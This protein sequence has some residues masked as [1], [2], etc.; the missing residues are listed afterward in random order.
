MK[1]IITNPGKSRE[2]H[3]LNY[4]AAGKYAGPAIV[5]QEKTDQKMLGFGAALTDSACILLGRMD[6]E[7]REA[8]L[9]E[10][11]SPQEGN[12]SVGRVCVGASDYADTPYSFAP[13]PDDMEMKHFD[14]SHDD[15]A[16]L[17][18]LRTC[19]KYNPDLYLFASPWS[20]PGWMKTSGRLQSGW[21]R[22]KYIDAFALYYLK[23]LRYY[24]KAGVKLNGLT[25]Q[26]ETETDQLGKMPACLWHPE[27]ET[28]FAMKM[29]R[30]L[31]D[32][33]FKE[34]KIWLL[35]HNLI[36]WRRAVFQMDDK[37]VKD[38]CAGIAWHPYDGHPE[39]ISW[40]R[41]KHPEC[42]NH[43]TEG[44][45]LPIDLATGFRKRYSIGDIAAGFIQAINNGCQSVTVWNLAL[46]PAGYP[47]IGPFNCAGT[48]EISRDGKSVRRSDEYYTLLHFSRYIKRGALR[49]VLEHKAL[50]RNFEAAGFVNPDNSRVIFVANT[51]SYDSDLILRDNSKDILLR[52]PRESV[53]TILL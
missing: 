53:N 49:L 25:P 13:V 17:P 32:N 2:E 36:M 34:L 50:P 24:E 9:K 22:E 19:R 47:N 14:A 11:Y 26:N 21:M 7:A 31:D 41:D 29:R 42:E 35:D 1:Q 18:V 51:E 43:W 8:L 5:V 39:M 46:D 12:F 23:F 37:A 4:E 48:V 44:G 38:A 33:G 16:I 15:A 28:R 30:L 27:I 20:P 40:F 45:V 6:E 3:S 52:I 10:I